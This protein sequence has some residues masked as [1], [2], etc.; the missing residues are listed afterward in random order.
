VTEPVEA[1]NIPPEAAVY[2][3]VVPFHD[4]DPLG[5]VWHGHY[6]KYLELARTVLLAKYRLDVPD[7]AALGHPLLM[8]ETRC[9]HVFPL[10]YGERYRVKAWLIDHE[11]RIHIGYEIENLTHARRTAR[12]WTTL[13]TTDREGNM[14]LATPDVLRDRIEGKT[15]A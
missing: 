6:Y 15:H 14:L 11:L 1:V 9:R 8:I 4:C 7:L 5:I 10:R 12:A 2:D 3:G 13:V